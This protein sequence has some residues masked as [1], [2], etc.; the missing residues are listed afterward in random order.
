MGY[1]RHQRAR[2][3]KH[4][5]RTAGDLTLNS[6]VWADL[7]SIG[8]TWDITLTAQTGDTV[9]CGLS[10]LVESAATIQLFDVQTIVSTVA[11][12][13]IGTQAAVSNSNGGVTGWYGATGVV[14]PVGGSAMYALVAGDIVTGT[15]TLRLRYRQSSA[16]NRTLNAT[17]VYPLHFSAR[18]LGPQ[19]PN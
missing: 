2:D 10:G 5:L 6:A 9:L 4:F 19:D 13:S 3:F 14:V 1:P 18:N 8:T 11:T 15:V 12:N 17:A 16:V 7:P